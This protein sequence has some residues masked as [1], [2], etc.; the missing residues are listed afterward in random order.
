MSNA[1]RAVHCHRHGS[2]GVS[3]GSQSPGVQGERPPCSPPPHWRSCT[4]AAGVGAVP[5][6]LVPSTRGHVEK[7]SFLFQGQRQKSP[8]L[9]LIYYFCFPVKCTGLY[10]GCKI[11]ETY[12]F[13]QI[14][15]Q[16]RILGSSPKLVR[17]TYGIQF[18]SSGVLMRINEVKCSKMVWGGWIMNVIHFTDTKHFKRYS[19]FLSQ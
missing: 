12:A 13:S 5:L 4:A 15:E 7:G 10:L 19:Q 18:L 16:T 2:A 8:G 1:E 6:L 17:S 3:C 11:L 9:R 14:E